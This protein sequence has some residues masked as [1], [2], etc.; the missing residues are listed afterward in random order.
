M[1]D[2][3]T[4]IK[5]MLRR[6]RFPHKELGCSPKFR[7]IVGTPFAIPTRSSRSRSAHSDHGRGGSDGLERLFLRAHF[8]TPRECVIL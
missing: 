3:C 8:A 2:L 4:S 5:A 6:K 1:K 7:A